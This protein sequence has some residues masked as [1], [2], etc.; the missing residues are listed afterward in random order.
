MGHREELSGDVE[1]L[2]F[3]AGNTTCRAAAHEAVE[4]RAQAEQVNDPVEF[5]LT[6]SVTPLPGEAKRRR[7][8]KVLPHSQIGV[9]DVLLHHVCQP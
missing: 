2:E 8:P 1:P 5:S 9:E 7:A 4:R 6:F 3:A